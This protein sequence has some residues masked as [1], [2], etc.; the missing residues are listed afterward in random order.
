MRLVLF[1]AALS[2]LSLRAESAVSDMVVVHDPISKLTTVTYRLGG[3]DAIVTLAAT[4]N[5]VAVADS[6]LVH[7]AGDANRLVR[8]DGAEKTL[9][10]RAR[11]LNRKMRRWRIRSRGRR[12][13]R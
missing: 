8:A 11:R 10:W 9:W 3:E 5:G 4:T 7:V 1:V 12:A 13:F 2:S 6:A